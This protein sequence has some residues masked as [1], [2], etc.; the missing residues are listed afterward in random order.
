MSIDKEG[1]LRG[2]AGRKLS[3]SMGCV[4]LL[5]SPSDIILE[6]NAFALMIITRK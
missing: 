2:A 3:I 5:R 4:A 1:L 6:T